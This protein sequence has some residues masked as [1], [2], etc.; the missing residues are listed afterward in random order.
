MNQ[1]SVLHHSDFKWAS[2]RLKSSE[3]WLFAQQLLQGECKENIKI[4]WK[5]FPSH[6]L[7]LELFTAIYRCCLTC[8]NS[9][10]NKYRLAVLM[11]YVDAQNMLV[12]LTYFTIN[13]YILILLGEK[14]SISSLI[15]IDRNWKGTGGWNYTSWK[16]THVFLTSGLVPWLLTS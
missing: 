2:L 12:V 10:A 5:L 16:E 4:L 14:Q 1:L 6:D 8:F 9:F 13:I 3:T 15:L 7:S 11:T